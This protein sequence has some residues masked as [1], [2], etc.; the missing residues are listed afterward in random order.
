[1]DP[2]LDDDY[3]L[4]QMNLMILAAS[5]CVKES[6]VQ[7]PTMSQVCA[8]YNFAYVQSGLSNSNMSGR[9]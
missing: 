7:R 3:N 8:S 9:H 4:L 6:S 5:L 2:A 1:M